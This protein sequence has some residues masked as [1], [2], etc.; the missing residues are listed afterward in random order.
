LIGRQ[1][2]ALNAW[3]IVL[4]VFITAIIFGLQHAKLSFSEDYSFKRRSV[5]I[6]IIAA[7]VLFIEWVL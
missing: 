5:E 1:V 7:I 2:A 4:F 6:A 3:D